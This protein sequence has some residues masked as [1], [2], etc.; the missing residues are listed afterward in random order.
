[1]DR[2]IGQKADII[3]LLYHSVNYDYAILSQK[4]VNKY[5]STFQGV[6]PNFSWGGDHFLRMVSGA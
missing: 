3:I 1:M 2:Q 5:Y 4:N 6:S